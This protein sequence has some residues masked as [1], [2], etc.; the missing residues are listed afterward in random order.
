MPKSN[1]NQNNLNQVNKAKTKV[2]FSSK[3]YFDGTITCQDKPPTPLICKYCDS[4]LYHI[5]FKIMESKFIW[6]TEETIRCTCNE[7]TKYWQ[8]YDTQKKEKLQEQQQHQ[9]SLKDQKRMKKLLGQSGIK[10]R[11]RNRTFEKFIIT[12]RNEDAF[13]FALYYANNFDKIYKTGK[14]LYIEGLYGTGKTHLAVSIAL[15]LIEQ[16][17]D[18]VCKTS[19]DI[20]SDIKKSYDNNTYYEYEILDMYKQVKLLVIDDF[21][22]EQSTFWS[23]SRFF[24]IL[25]DRYENLMPTIITTNYNQDDLI[26]RL[27][28]PDN[29][30]SNAKAIVSRLRES[31]D[32]ITMLCEDYR[33]M[34]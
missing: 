12:D 27:T 24:E 17:I 20:L 28:P 25:N 30:S 1:Q 3:D 7:S 29:D 4:K 26:K 9:Q 19:I 5:G 13:K 8:N 22:K 15:K 32:I 6:I 2:K 18:V 31:N 10:E 33:K 11:F 23:V 21:G 34:Q 16:N 14:G